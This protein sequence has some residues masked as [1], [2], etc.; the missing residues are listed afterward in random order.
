MIKIDDYQKSIQKLIN[1]YKKYIDED[2]LVS[3][4]NYIFTKCKNK[5]NGNN[6]FHTYFYISL[7]QYLKKVYKKEMVYNYIYN[8]KNID[9]VIITD[10]DFENKII[11]EI[12]FEIY[13]NHLSKKAKFIVDLIC[14]KNESIENEKE[15]ITKEKIKKLLIEK[16]NWIPAEVNFR[17]KEIEMMLYSY[18]R[19]DDNV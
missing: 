3:I 16:Y 1:S 13:K 9:V 4:S 7:K 2:E 8:N 10:N 19:R 12:D 17:F 14:N 6:E 11:N 18:E 5:Y 15:N